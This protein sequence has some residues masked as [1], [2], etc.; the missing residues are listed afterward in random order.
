MSKDIEDLDL[1]NMSDEDELVEIDW[2]PLQGAIDALHASDLDF[3][4]NRNLLDHW[5]ALLG[6]LLRKVYAE[7]N[8]EE[9]EVAEL[10]AETAAFGIDLAFG[11]EEL[12]DFAPT[13]PRDQN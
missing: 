10:A 1:E 12:P 3:T 4:D 7:E 8:L 2:E 13:V 11:P 9:E 6:A 5:G